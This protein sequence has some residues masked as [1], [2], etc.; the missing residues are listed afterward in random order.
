MGVTLR[1]ARITAE[2][3]FDARGTL[4]VAK[5]APVGITDIRLDFHLDTDADEET[6][7]KL[8]TLSERFCVIYQ[9]LKGPP[10]ISVG[11]RITTEA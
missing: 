10:D 11:H 9:T 2:G 4:G 7:A 6:V 3:H 1:G 5:E 8:I